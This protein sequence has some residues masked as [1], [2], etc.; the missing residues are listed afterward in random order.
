MQRAFRRVAAHSQSLTNSNELS[1]D[2]DDPVTMRQLECNGCNGA[3]GTRTTCG[4]KACWSVGS[5][6]HDAGRCS[7][8]CPY[9]LAGK[10]CFDGLHCLMCHLDHAK[11]YESI[12]RAL[13]MVK[14]RAGARAQRACKVSELLNK[15]SL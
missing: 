10:E 15:I 1:K 7:K 3:K 2:S 4:V 9:V 5:A 12:K 6:G 14:S 8:P 11:D 13:S